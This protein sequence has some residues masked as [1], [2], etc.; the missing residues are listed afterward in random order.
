V[1]ISE[2]LV[3]GACS[4]GVPNCFVFKLSEAKLRGTDDEK[5]CDEAKTPCSK[6]RATFQVS[7]TAST[8]ALSIVHGLVA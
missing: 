4:Q 6:L 8:V 1:L 7:S 5:Q 2:V 3:L